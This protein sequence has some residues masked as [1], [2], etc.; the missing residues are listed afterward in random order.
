ME[1]IFVIEELN[2]H[3]MYG[4][5]WVLVEGTT[6]SKTYEGAKNQI[7][8]LKIKK[9]GY[10]YVDLRIQKYFRFELENGESVEA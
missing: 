10:K 6:I 5:S 9:K 8:K 7:S 4:P 1:E 2:T 3:I